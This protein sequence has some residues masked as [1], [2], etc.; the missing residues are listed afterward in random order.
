MVILQES[1]RTPPGRGYPFYLRAL[2]RHPLFYVPLRCG[3]Q[4]A[5][6][7][8]CTCNSALTCKHREKPPKAASRV[9]KQFKCDKLACSI[10]LPGL[11]FLLPACPRYAQLVSYRSGLEPQTIYISETG[12]RRCDRFVL[13]SVQAKI[14]VAEVIGGVDNKNVDALALARACDITCGSDPT[15]E[16]TSPRFHVIPPKYS[17]AAL[18][19]SP[20][21]F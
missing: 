9:Q 19:P 8:F 6:H 16:S 5:P 14:P 20:V 17:T 7:Y 3:V 21:R 4:I 10:L 13:D 1:D 12:V 11:L 2:L 18:D 15:S